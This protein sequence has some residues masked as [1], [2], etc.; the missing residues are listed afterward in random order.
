ML[1]TQWALTQWKVL[2]KVLSS[3]RVL[4]HIRGRVRR[5]T[6]EGASAELGDK[7]SSREEAVLCSISSTSKT[8]VTRQV[9]FLKG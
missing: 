4:G 9:F 5:D 8:V 2:L 6:G 7:F 3:G 1:D